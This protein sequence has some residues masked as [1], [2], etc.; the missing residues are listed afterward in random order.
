MKMSAS[1]VTVSSEI[2]TFHLAGKLFKPEDKQLKIVS[3][4][5]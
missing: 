2:E 4:S 1:C 5:P 3:G